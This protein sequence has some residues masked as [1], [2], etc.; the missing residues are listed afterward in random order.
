M[1]RAFSRQVFAKAQISSFIEILPVRAEF[2]ADIRT[3]L[4]NLIVAL[5]NFAK[6]P[7][8]RTLLSL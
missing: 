2:H 1:K 8:E 7:N 4:T 5:C 6:A 3:D